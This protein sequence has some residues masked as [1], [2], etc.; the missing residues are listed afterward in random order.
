MVEWILFSLLWCSNLF[1][2][3][4]YIT[5][6]IKHEKTYDKYFYLVQRGE[7][8]Y[9]WCVAEFP[10]VGYAAL[11][12]VAWDARQTHVKEAI[13]PTVKGSTDQFRE[14]LRRGFKDKKDSK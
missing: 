9:T 1:F 14:Y 12:V 11:H 6:K 2:I 8:L 5:E 3:Y 13:N 4:K 10:Q 7:E